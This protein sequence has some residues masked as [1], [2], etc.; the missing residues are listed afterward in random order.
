MARYSLGQPVRLSTTVTT[1]AGVLANPGAITLTITRPDATQVVYSAP[2]NDGPGLYHQDSP[3]TDLG[4]VGHYQYLWTSTGLNAGE[5]FGDFDVFN[6]A[7]DTAVLPLQDAKAMLNIPQA[8]TTS[9]AELQ[10]FIATIE[11]SLESFTGGPLITRTVSNER[12][13][14]TA[15][16]TILQIRQRPLVSV[17]SIVSASS[18]LPLDISAG[19]D[20][21][22]NAG[23]IRRQLGWPFYGPYFQW[24]PAMLVTYTA[25]WGTAVPPAFN[26]AARIIL[27]H[28]WQTQRGATTGSLMGGEETVLVPGFGFAIPNRAAELLTN[29]SQNGMPFTSQVY[30]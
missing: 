14:L 11:S 12:A 15:N 5:S 7:T 18:G 26:V 30:V 8:T 6:A 21:D 2:V 4:Q 27:A 16:F 10:A 23:I 24:L 17:T 22:T 3:V 25:G 1:I 20:L 28:L 9:D 13:V 19:L 29:G